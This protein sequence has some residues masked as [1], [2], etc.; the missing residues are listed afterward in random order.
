[1]VDEHVL[2]DRA[3]DLR[4]EVLL[5]HRQGEI[6]ACRHPS[7]CPDRAVDNEDAILLDLK[8]GYRSRR[9]R[10]NRQCVVAL[11]P[12]SAP[13]SA[14]MNAP[15]QV[16][17]TRRAVRVLFLHERKQTVRWLLP[18]SGSSN[19]HRDRRPLP[20]WFLHR[21]RSPKRNERGRRSRKSQTPLCRPAPAWR[22]LRTRRRSCGGEPHRLEIRRR[23]DQADVL[24]DR[25]HVLKGGL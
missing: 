7:R 11:W 21:P 12:S 15:V 17:A 9:S 5:H 14:S 24:Y 19:D 23:Q 2:G 1:M 18:P 25:L 16:A 3:G 13:A 10:A 8:L 4:S 22:G 20:E 6:D